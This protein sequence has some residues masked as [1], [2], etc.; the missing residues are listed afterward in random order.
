MNRVI[1]KYN[2]N[3]GNSLQNKVVDSSETAVN[4]TYG[5]AGT[6]PVNL[7]AY[8][9]G[10]LIGQTKSPVTI[11]DCSVK[12]PNIFTPN[13]DGANDVWFIENIEYYPNATVSIFNRLGMIVWESSKGYTQMWDGRNSEKQDLEE[14]TYYYVIDFKDEEKKSRIKRGCITLLRDVHSK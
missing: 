11:E 12:A 10:C 8:Y 3:F 1:D 9:K 5:D 7:E 6:Y 2:W 4:Y 14:D 13:G